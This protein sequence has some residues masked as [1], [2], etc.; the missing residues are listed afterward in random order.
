MCIGEYGQV[1]EWPDGRCLLDQPVKLMTAF[2]IIADTLE[3]LR[4]GE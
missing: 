4:K 2:N 1:R 3:S